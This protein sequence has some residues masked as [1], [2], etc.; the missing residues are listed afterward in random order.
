MAE[1]PT[2]E[3]SFE[4]E[5]DSTQPHRRTRQGRDLVSYDQ[6]DIGKLNDDMLLEIFDC[7]RQTGEFDWKYDRWWYKLM[8]VCQRWRNLILESASRLKLFLCFANRFRNRASATNV[9]SRSPPFPLV[10]R[11]SIVT[12]KDEHDVSH[13][14][15]QRERV[16]DVTLQFIPAPALRKLVACMD[17]QFP[18]L[19]SLDV[20][21][22][23]ND[24]GQ[25]LPDT[26]EA[27]R[28]SRMHLSN[29]ALPPKLTF[30][31]SAVDLTSLQLARIPQSAS[32]DPH[33]FVEQ[34]PATS[35]LKHL[36]IWFLS[37]P[38]PKPDVD[39]DHRPARRKPMVHLVDLQF[40]G[41][42]AYL[43]ALVSLISAPVLRHLNITFFYQPS[44]SV[45]HLVEF[46]GTSDTLRF[47]E[48]IVQFRTHFGSISLHPRGRADSSRGISIRVGCKQI[49]W[50]VFAA[51]QI[52]HQLE[53]LLNPVQDLVLESY[54][55]SPQHPVDVD[56]DQWLT[57]LRSFGGAE[58]V[59][60]G[61][62]LIS[63]LCLALP[64]D[65]ETV[66]EGLLPRLGHLMLEANDGTALEPF[67]RA[68]QRTGRRV[69]LRL[70][71][72]PDR[73]NY[74]RNP[75]LR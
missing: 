45:P 33:R 49:E 63:E 73:P 34:I 3:E 66:D 22:R 68:C 29:V 75:K 56:R 48:S 52:C 50:Q 38:H 28:V 26:F 7:Y 1:T 13:L 53:S 59:R 2:R 64:R 9:L 62:N 4:S 72:R 44:F 23:A 55:S 6:S 37:H 67:I 41:E 14:L 69:E 15:R 57:L 20:T 40:R 12:P 47:S 51:S 54:D 32:F 70:F 61:K 71:S 5:I 30:L 43:E 27:P 11:Y 35:R 74:G 18:L 19:Q 65:G 39:Q 21:T 25:I 42:S 31:A 24:E 60:I 16:R 46:I 17:G 36:S 10:L 58:R 8:H